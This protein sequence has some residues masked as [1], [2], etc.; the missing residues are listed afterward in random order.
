MIDN[1]KTPDLTSLV[2]NGIFSKVD[3]DH[4]GLT[5]NSFARD[6]VLRFYMVRR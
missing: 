1:D 3:V 5:A 6:Q 2:K 4:L